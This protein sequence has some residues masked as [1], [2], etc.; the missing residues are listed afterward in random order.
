MT[1]E[2]VAG[3]CVEHAAAKEDGTDQDVEDVEH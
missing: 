3:D 1:S 2:V